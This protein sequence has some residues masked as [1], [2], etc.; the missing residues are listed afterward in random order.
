[1]LCSRQRNAPVRE[2][3]RD[4]RSKPLAH[5][6]DGMRGLGGGVA[7]WRGGAGWCKCHMAKLHVIMAFNAATER[8][9]DLQAPRQHESYGLW[10]HGSKALQ[11]SACSQ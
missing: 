1:M 6:T 7:G 11:C 9:L 10:P 3:A 5:L 2:A 8:H 4:Q